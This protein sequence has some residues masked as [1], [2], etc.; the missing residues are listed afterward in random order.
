MS[1]MEEALRFPGTAKNGTEEN[2][3]LHLQGTDSKSVRKEPISGREKSGVYSVCKD[4][5]C[6]ERPIIGMRNFHNSAAAEEI[7]DTHHLEN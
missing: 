5:L 4:T 7:E 6:M 3:V 2:R 1:D